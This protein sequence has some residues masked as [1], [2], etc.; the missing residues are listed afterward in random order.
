M[1]IFGIGMDFDQPLAFSGTVSSMT[2]ANPSGTPVF[3]L[4]GMNVPLARRG[5]PTTLSGPTPEPLILPQYIGFL[6]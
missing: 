4:T 2:Y 3:S 6:I 5:A 1:H